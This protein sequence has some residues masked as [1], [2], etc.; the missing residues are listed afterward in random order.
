MIIEIFRYNSDRDHSNGLSLVNGRFE[1]YTL[2]DEYRTQ[3]VYGETRIP[4]GE[5]QV[6]FRT[7]GG[8][9]NR[10]RAKYGAWHEGMLE[11]QDVPNFTYVLIHKGNDDDDT[12]GC[13]LVGTSNDWGS[14]WIG[15]STQAYE[16]LYPKVRNALNSG[17]EVVLKITTL[18]KPGAT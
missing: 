11:L 13:I 2:E 7:E 9:H 17:E 4:D 10:Y 8:F 5:Y 16:R 12:A 1:C 6:K 3:K 18:D 15:S 14:N